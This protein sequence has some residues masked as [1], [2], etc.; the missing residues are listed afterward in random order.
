MVDFRALVRVLADTGFFTIQPDHAFARVARVRMHS[1]TCGKDLQMMASCQPPPISK[2]CG[3]ARL[4][5]KAN[6]Y[7][8]KAH[9]AQALALN[10]SPQNILIWD[11]RHLLRNRL[12]ALTPTHE[13]RPDRKKKKKKKKIQCKWCS[14]SFKSAALQSVYLAEDFSPKKPPSTIASASLVVS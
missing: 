13:Q 4:P 14:Q 12:F 7:T 6:A 10:S 9:K 3:D 8:N 1:T 11:R 2:F 5:I